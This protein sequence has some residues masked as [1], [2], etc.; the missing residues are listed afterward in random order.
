MAKLQARGYQSLNPMRIREYF[1]H[2]LAKYS[3]CP[4]DLKINLTMFLTYVS[5]LSTEF[6]GGKEMIEL[7]KLYR[8]NKVLG[9]VT[10]NTSL[11]IMSAWEPVRILYPKASPKNK[12]T[13][14]CIVIGTVCPKPQKLKFILVFA[15]TVNS[16]VPK[17]TIK[18]IFFV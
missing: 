7:K 10:F 11:G 9:A 4:A 17:I 15:E 13:N 18:K 3:N 2:V 6:F 16:T 1:R 8:W 14:V 12:T 5:I